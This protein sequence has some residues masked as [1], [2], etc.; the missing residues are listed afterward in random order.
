MSKCLL[1]KDWVA[2]NSWILCSTSMLNIWFII[3]V[4]WNFSSITCR[5]LHSLLHCVTSIILTGQS[6]NLFDFPTVELREWVDGH[7]EGR[8]RPYDLVPKTLTSRTA[9]KRSFEHPKSRI[10]DN[11]S[12]KWKR[13]LLLWKEK[14]K[15]PLDKEL[16]TFMLNERWKQLYSMKVYLTLMCGYGT[17]ADISIHVPL[18]VLEAL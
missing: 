12:R 15:W 4:H 10:I 9:I 14:Q 6:L 5:M 18:N 2:S 7:R 16:D 13:R 17:W 3:R 1:F 11:R 8:P